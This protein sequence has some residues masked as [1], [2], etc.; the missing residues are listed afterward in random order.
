MAVGF[1]GEVG[2]REVYDREGVRDGHAHGVGWTVYHLLTVTCDSVIC[3]CL[4]RHVRSV[5]LV[6]AVQIRGR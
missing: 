4:W 6:C 2:I 5:R 3:S 1:G